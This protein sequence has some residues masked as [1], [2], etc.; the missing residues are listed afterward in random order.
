MCRLVPRKKTPE[1]RRGRKAAF[2]R[3]LNTSTDPEIV[4]FLVQ[5]RMQRPSH[6]RIYHLHHVQDR[7]DT[8]SNVNQDKEK[9]K[10]TNSSE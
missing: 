2:E 5:V 3:D 8:L 7:S 4:I 6:V 9:E 1:K 10:N